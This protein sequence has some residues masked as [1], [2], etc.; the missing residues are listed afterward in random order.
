MEKAPSTL[1]AGRITL[2]GGQQVLGPGAR[3][4]VEA[5]RCG[6]SA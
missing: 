1:A 5:C 3:F 6:C 4:P 2:T